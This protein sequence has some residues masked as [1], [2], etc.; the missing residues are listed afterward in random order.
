[1]ADLFMMDLG[2]QEFA[3][4][5]PVTVLAPVM[6]LGTHLE[7]DDLGGLEVLNDLGFNPH[8]VQE[9]PSNL[10]IAILLDGKYS[11]EADPAAWLSLEHQKDA[12]QA[13]RYQCGDLL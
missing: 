9:G 8:I 10:E 13:G 12:C 1:M 7:D 11:R 5:L 3:H 4:G 6:L 2:D